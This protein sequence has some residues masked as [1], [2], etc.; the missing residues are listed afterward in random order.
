MLLYIGIFISGFL[1]GS[2]AMF[3]LHGSIIGDMQRLLTS[4]ANDINAI[5]SKLVP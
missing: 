5:K 1:V 2:V 4:L 3:I